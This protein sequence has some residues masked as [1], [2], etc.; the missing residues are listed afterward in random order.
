MTRIT[1]SYLLQEII[2]EV[3]LLLHLC[4]RRGHV[5]FYLNWRIDLFLIH[6]YGLSM[7]NDFQWSF[8]VLKDFLN[9]I[10]FK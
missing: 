7:Q 9:V 8:Q 5:N 10:I 3:N 4:I 2:T 1:E 6:N